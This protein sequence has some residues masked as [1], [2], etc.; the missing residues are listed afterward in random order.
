[1]RPSPSRSL[2]SG[3]HAA[4]LGRSLRRA[5]ALSARIILVGCGASSVGDPGASSSPSVTAIVIAPT[6]LTLIAGE[7]G[8][9]TATLNTTG[10]PAGGW[11]TSWKSSDTSVV[12]VSSSGTLAARSAGSATVT[13]TAGG[14]SASA[15]VTVQP[16]VS[17]LDISVPI[18]KFIAVG[19]TRTLSVSV[20]SPLPAPVGGWNVVWTTSDPAIATLTQTGVV[21]AVA[22]GTDTVTATLE[23]ASASIVLEVL[24]QPGLVDLSLN[25]QDFDL[26]LTD[27]ATLNAQAT[28]VGTLPAGGLTFTWTSSD[29]SVAT[30]VGSDENGV[31]TAVA[32]GTATI[33]VTGYGKSSSVK[34]TVVPG[35]TSSLPPGTVSAIAL[36]SPY[37]LTWPTAQASVTALVT[38]S[39]AEP[40]DGWPVVWTTADTT[41]AKMGT[42]N[43]QYAGVAGV[44]NGR[45]TVTATLQGKS[46][47][48][49]VYVATL[50]SFALSDTALSIPVGDQATIGTTSTTVGPLP[51]SGWS[52]GWTSSS[53]LVATVSPAGV[54]T[55]IGVG[56]TRIGASSSDKYRTAVITVTGT[57]P[58]LTLAT[59]DTLQGT[60]IATTSGYVLECIHAIKVTVSGPGVIVGTD[61]YQSVGGGPYDWTG[62]SSWGQY[63]EGVPANDLVVRNESGPVASPAQLSP[64][65]IGRQYHYAINA[66]F[67]DVKSLAA[68]YVA[69]VNLVCKP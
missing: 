64:S 24:S 1:M 31:V 65:T 18:S 2:R 44:A 47:S 13:A 7:Q 46:A 54:V 40:A 45:T 20:T 50:T 30:V 52:V 10:T 16:A 53:P 26:A 15:V 14:K 69:T 5:L 17:S 38:A 22:P 51:P 56:K 41:V 29:P 59:P 12:V 35:T 9:L 61:V 19:A 48:A 34:V 36:E 55:A 8:T 60:V 28:L 66:D 62:I 63:S 6:T 27:E 42:A 32:L 21:S 33:T 3:H 67:F 39:V 25:T 23:G 57:P 58:T 68:D 4:R 49:D 37:V 11:T 43:A